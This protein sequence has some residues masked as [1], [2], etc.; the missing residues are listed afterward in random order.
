MPR[1][2]L[3]DGV[4]PNCGQANPV[5]TPCATEV[6]LRR[7]YHCVPKEF[8]ANARAT[9]DPNIGTI[10]GD[11]LLVRALGQGGFG[12]VYLALQAPLWHLTAVKRLFRDADADVHQTRLAE[13]TTEARAL[14]SL[15]HPNIVRLIRLGEDEEGAYLVME[16][17]EGA[18]TLKNLLRSR[19]RHGKPLH[20]EEARRIL[21]Q[22][23]DA[24]EAAHAASIIHRDIKPENLM[25]TEAPG[26]PLLVKV[27]D[28]GLAKDI[29]VAT[30]THLAAG[31]PMYMAPEQVRQRHIGP[32]TDLYAVGVIAYELLLG[33][34]P[35]PMASVEALITA[36]LNPAYDFLEPAQRTGPLPDP[37]ARFFSQALAI[38]HETRFNSVAAFR[39]GLE[40][41]IAALDSSPRMASDVSVPVDREPGA[42]TSPPISSG[43]A[44]S[45]RV[46]ESSAAHATSTDPPVKAVGTGLVK[47]Q[48]RGRGL[49]IALLVSL[50]IATTAMVVWRLTSTG[51][52]NL[53]AN[54]PTQALPANIDIGMGIDLAGLDTEAGK[55]LLEL[56][57]LTQENAD[58]LLATVGIQG[59]PFIAG[60]LRVGKTTESAE[61]IV[62]VPAANV[63]GTLD[64]SQVG[65]PGAGAA[66][67]ERRARD[68]V[69]FGNPTLV[70][71][72][73][74]ALRKE[75][76][77]FVSREDIAGHL[78]IVPDKGL[79][80]IVDPD[81]L[82]RSLPPETPALASAV[83]H[84]RSGLIAV[85][86]ED[87]LDGVAALYLDE[88][89]AAST[90]KALEPAI[91][92]TASQATNALDRLLA[93][94]LTVVSEGALV[95][96]RTH[97][98]TDV[99]IGASRNLDWP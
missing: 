96:A 9:L 43:Q 66:L 61:I 47:P 82:T 22:L 50:A 23:L 17:V 90:A 81:T 97:V 4:C 91:K 68:L 20:R 19:A 94:R 42:S 49:W 74:A 84:A 6:C 26:H 38:S 28:F 44:S 69:L 33:E 11:Q 83:A 40:E 34:R 58:A 67:I 35:Y 12:A 27:V 32:W 1:F 54:G 65:L 16:Y 53:S 2:D 59:R 64:I 52:E 62:V 73:E 92:E 46:S 79:W 51:S 10:L 80:A 25:V 93:E 37:V 88:E 13:L 57:G 39:A 60:G 89:S 15:S 75:S 8:V 99:L 56:T 71:D 5:G 18:Q 72:A 70:G 21:G 7:A 95:I 86:L 98:S 3:D 41:A 48:R 55:V 31:T 45:A 87:G 29:S 78:A 77:R 30:H 85:G 24:L 76:P 14:A 36:K 63:R